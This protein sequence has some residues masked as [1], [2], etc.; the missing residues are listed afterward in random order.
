[1]IVTVKMTASNCKS[2]RR[3]SKSV[4]TPSITFWSSFVENGDQVR[5]LHPKLPF[6]QVFLK[7][8]LRFGFLTLDYR[9][10]EFY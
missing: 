10:V 4:S 2:E 7:T 8:A 1:M 9:L 5:N 6:G 3:T